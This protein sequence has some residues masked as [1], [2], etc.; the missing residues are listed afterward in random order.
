MRLHKLCATLIA[1][2]V[3]IP[4]LAQVVPTDGVCETCDAVG[5]LPTPGILGLVVLG[6]V[7]AIGLAR[8][9]H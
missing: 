9:Y 6:V 4:A 7:A 2:V 5:T 8:R 3:S 1:T